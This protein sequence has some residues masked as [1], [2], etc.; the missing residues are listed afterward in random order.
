M[1]EQFDHIDEQITAYVKGQLKGQ[2]LVTFEEH[3]KADN[4]LLDKVN[5]EKEARD[6]FLDA[7][8]LALKEQM[9]Q[10]M[11][12]SS[13]SSKRWLIGG[14]GVLII[15]STV[16]L[17]ESQKEDRREEASKT[18]V[19][20]RIEKNEEKASYKKGSERSVDKHLIIVNEVVDEEN[21]ELLDS[22]IVNN[23]SQE[24]TELTTSGI[25]TITLKENSEHIDGA[26][27]NVNADSENIEKL[28]PCIGISFK[29]SPLIKSTIAGEENGQITLDE[30]GIRGGVKPYSYALNH[31]GEFEERKAFSDLQADHYVIYIKDDN[32]CVGALENGK[33]WEVKT[34]YCLSDY[35]KTFN[36]VY[37]NKWEVPLVTGEAAEITLINKVGQELLKIEIEEGEKFHWDGTFDTGNKVVQGRYNWLIKYEN[38]EQC[39]AKMSVLN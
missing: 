22:I 23:G 14:A 31:I 4:A 30:F 28:D 2:E 32:G 25:Q 8:V 20:P 13:G 12:S 17:W 1:G 16:L 37:E 6:L 15:L 36:I 39:I 29:G 38:G 35:Q 21:N 26:T 9:K 19:V 7:D 34:S 5:L 3:L 24:V 33:T 27:D 10:D 11:S 18:I